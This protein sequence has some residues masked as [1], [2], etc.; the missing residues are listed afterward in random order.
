MLFKTYNFS[1]IE[2][3]RGNKKFVAETMIP[4]TLKLKQG[5]QKR[6]ELDCS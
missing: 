1:I 4:Q 6:R 3:K 5:K 2:K